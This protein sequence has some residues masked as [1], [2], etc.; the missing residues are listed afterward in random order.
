MVAF[1]L[2]LCL[3]ACLSSPPLYNEPT[4]GSAPAPV[5][6]EVTE[7]TEDHLRCL[8]R[9]RCQNEQIVFHRDGLA[10]RIFRSGTEIDSVFMARIDSV[11]FAALARSLIELH[12]FTES[13]GFAGHHEPLANESYVLTAATLCRRAYRTLSAPP[14]NFEAP[15]LRPVD[16][17]TA[18]TKWQ[19]PLRAEF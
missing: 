6:Y 12:F 19:G 17:L 10:S 16:S 4:W 15:F 1:L 18:A 14:R 13:D 9:P 11:S 8:Q 3:A 7:V 5:G 2:P